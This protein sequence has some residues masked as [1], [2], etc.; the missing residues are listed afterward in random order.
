MPPE[1][2]KSG[3]DGHL[4]GVG[5][6]IEAKTMRAHSPLSCRAEPVITRD[7]GIRSGMVRNVKPIEE[8]TDRMTAQTSEEAVEHA[9]QPR[10]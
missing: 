7:L 2:C 6:W 10:K 1:L 8:E 5:R 9:P 3:R 4:T